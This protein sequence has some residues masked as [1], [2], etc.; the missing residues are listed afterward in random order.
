MAKASKIMKKHIRLINTLLSASLLLLTL[1][2]TSLS[3]AAVDA[4]NA[5][6]LEFV[7]ATQLEDSIQLNQAYEKYQQISEQYSESVIG[8]LSKIRLNELDTQVF[9][10]GVKVDN[11]TYPQASKLALIN[12]VVKALS[13]HDY[14][15]FFAHLVMPENGTV[16]FEGVE[17]E[18]YNKLI[19]Q[20]SGL[21]ADIRERLINDYKA[22]AV[23]LQ[24]ET[25]TSFASA[26]INA[27]QSQ[28]NLS[29]NGCFTAE[30]INTCYN[31]RTAQGH[32]HII[33][34]QAGR[35]YLSGV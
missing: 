24:N 16:Y 18:E 6:N 14:Q 26:I 4:A 30:S 32:R 31:Y 5:V 27:E 15:Y 34:E 28:F 23:S 22:I 19:K 2:Y 12:S 7:T 29:I 20:V 10:N 9:R 17:Q 25:E 3:F 35:F 1:S 11:D 33:L 13:N 8:K 21:K